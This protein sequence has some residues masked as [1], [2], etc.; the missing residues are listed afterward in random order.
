MTKILGI[1]GGI[2]SGKSTV[3]KLLQQQG[4]DIIDADVIARDIVAPG[5]NAL[6]TIAEH[7]GDDVLNEDASLNRALLRQKIFDH[8]AD[9][10]W[11][12]GLTHPLIRETINRQIAESYSET[13]C[14]VIPLLKSRDDYPMIEKLIVVDVDEATQIERLI[15]RDNIDNA[16]AKKMISSQHPRSK[17]NAMAD[18]VIENQSS[19]EQLQ[20]ICNKLIT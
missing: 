18:V 5:T 11:L 19:I 2:A 12:E 8:P 16:L 15:Q 9:R 17:R 6:A 14:L 3:A 10:Q 13:I 1:T 4:V 20:S 7:F